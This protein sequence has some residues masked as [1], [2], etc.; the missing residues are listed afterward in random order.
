MAIIGTCSLCG[1]PVTVPNYLNVISLI[2]ATPACAQC[3]AVPM[4]THSPVIPMRLQVPNQWEHGQR[5]FIYPSKIVGETQ[6][7]Y[8]YEKYPLMLDSRGRLANH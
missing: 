8:P 5:T 6:D 7:E 3:G 2:P 4:D 1:G